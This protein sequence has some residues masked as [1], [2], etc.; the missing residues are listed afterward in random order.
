MPVGAF[1]GRGSPEGKFVKRR[2]CGT[3]GKG[4]CRNS[5]EAC[6]SLSFHRLPADK[7]LRK[8]WIAKI[9]PVNLPLTANTYVC[10]VHFDGG[11]REGVESLPI[12]Y[13]WSTKRKARTTRASVAAR[14]DST[15]VASKPEQPCADSS[16]CG[17]VFTPELQDPPSTDNGY[18]AEDI[19]VHLKQQL[20]TC[21]I[22]KHS[23][24]RFLESW[25]RRR[26]EWS[27]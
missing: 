19:V 2:L 1:R 24:W 10:G 15:T 6:R 4:G 25:L 17:P 3:D 26:V 20:S 14:S 22:C 8:E 11:S 27:T 13:A 7:N 12:V 9:Q 16:D 21:H 18:T 5:A 23:F